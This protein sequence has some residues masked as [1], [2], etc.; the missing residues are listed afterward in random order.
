MTMYW[1]YDFPNW[2]LGVLIIAVFVLGAVAGLYATRPAVGRFLGRSNEYN[3]LVNYF[4]AAVGVFYGLAMGLI[5][6]GTWTN[7][8]AVDGQ[9][10][11]EATALTGLYRDLDGYPAPVRNSLEEKLRQ[12]TSF[13]IKGDWVA[14]RQGETNVEGDHLLEHFENE[15]MAY[16]PTSEREKITHAEVLRS[17]HEVVEQRALR[18]QS[19]GT[20]LPSAVW[21][22]L[23]VGAVLTIGLTF[24]IW[25]EKTGLHAILVAILATFLGLLIFLTA[26]MDN[27]FRGEFSVSP[28]AFNEVLTK[29]MTPESA[30]SPAAEHAK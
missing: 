3:D 12:Y 26:A 14:H 25:V 8:T 17:L 30:P 20:G 15:A 10:T 2:L 27:P 29:V 7:F 16:E 24:L 13:I 4:F 23:L 22:V 28:D 9:V 1:I 19:V 21:I 5:A 18:V 11:Q 6:V